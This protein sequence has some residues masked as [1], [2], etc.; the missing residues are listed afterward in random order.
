MAMK[1]VDLKAEI[2]T[3]AGVTQAQVDLVIKTFRS[4]VEEK[5]LT[6][7]SISIPSLVKFEAVDV[8]AKSGSMVTYKKNEDGK[9]LDADGNVTTV[10]SERVI[11]TQRDWTK[12]AHT[13]I[14]A[15]VLG[16]MKT[17]IEVQSNPDLAVETETE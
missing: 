9:Y 16:S 5:L 14:K 6:E 12:P 2:G 10:K 13:T 15:K 4:I 17:K 7:G 11:D 1:Y 8:V 3:R